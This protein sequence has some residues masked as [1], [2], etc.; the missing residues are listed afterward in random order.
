[1]KIDQALLKQIT[2]QATV[3]PTSIAALL[4]SIHQTPELREWVTLESIALPPVPVWRGEAWGLITLLAVPTALDNGEAAWFAPWGAVEWRL[5][6]RQVIQKIDLRQQE[7]F[8]ALRQ[9]RIF[10]NHPAKPE[11]SDHSSFKQRKEKL[12]QT[13]DQML[14]AQVDFEQLA[15]IYASLLP[16]ELYPY[17]HALIPDSKAWLLANADTVP[18]I[19]PV[20]STLPPC[21]LSNAI[22]PWLRQAVQIAEKFGLTTIQSEL[23]QIDKRRRLP[24]FRLA[25]VGEFSRGKSTLINSLLGREVL[26]VGAKPTTAAL[27]SILPGSEDEMMVFWNPETSDRR[28]LQNTSWH[29]LLAVDAVGKDQDVP[30]NVRII[31]DNSWLRSLNAELIDTPGAGDLNGQRAALVSDLLSQS[32]AAIL[33]LSASIPFSLTERAFLEQEVL[34]R[35]VSKVLVVVSKLDT[36][37]LEERPQILQLIQERISQISPAIPVLPVYPVQA[38]EL[39]SQTLTSLRDYIEVMATQ[40]D[41]HLWRNRQ[42]CGQLSDTVGRMAAIGVEASAAAQLNATELKQ[43]QAQ[44]EAALNETDLQ[45]ES[46]RLMLEQRRIHQQQQIQERINSIRQD[47]MESLSVDL[48][49][50]PEPKIWWERDLPFRMRRELITLSRQLEETMLKAIA[51]DMEWLD[52]TIAQTFDTQLSPRER[53]PHL[54]PIQPNYTELKLTNTSRYRLLTRLGSSVAALGGCVLGGPVGIAASTGVWL[55]GEHLLNQEVNV[56]RQKLEQ[57]LETCIGKAI[58]LYGRAVGDRLRQVYQR[59]FQDTQRQQ[60]AWLA[61]RQNALKTNFCPPDESWSELITL[62]NTLQQ[63]INAAINV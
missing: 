24:G 39:E 5:S 29:D 27:I 28:P 9:P 59:V 21:D 6:D 54:K 7:D 14:N 26:P 53:L 34:G 10:T 3:P 36:I 35:H 42:I 56:Q 8:A 61:I 51:Q 33:V 1:M 18:P 15:V 44:A 41:R 52:E 62:S 60:V 46:I 47:V 23:Q 55:L 16:L 45:W 4:H 19:P 48:S 63:Q 20:E 2:A 43:A 50:T 37:P 58:D 11:F 17:Y 40:S 31:M 32:D 13:L 22:N 49:R 38:D 30:A 57:E 12:L 25:V